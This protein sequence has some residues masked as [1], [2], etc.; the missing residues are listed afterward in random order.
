M[1]QFFHKHFQ[2]QKRDISHCPYNM[3]DTSQLTN[4]TSKIALNL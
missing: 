2:A 1:A 3:T 4:A